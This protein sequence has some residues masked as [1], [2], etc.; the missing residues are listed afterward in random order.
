MEVGSYRPRSRCERFFCFS[1]F[2]EKKRKGSK[3]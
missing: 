1:F 3:T 2:R